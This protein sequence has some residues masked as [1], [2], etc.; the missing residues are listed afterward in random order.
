[1]FRFAHSSV[2]YLLILVPLLIAFFVV[3]RMR[4]RRALATFGED[5]LLAPLMPLTSDARETFKFILLILA[6][7]LLIIGAAG[8]QFGSKL[9]QVKK[10]GVELEILI[11]VSNSMLAEDIKPN[12]LERSKMAVERMM[13]RLYDDKVGVIIFAGDAYVQ[14]PITTDYSAAKL[15]LSS[16]STT[17]VPIQGTAIGRA[18]DLAMRSFSP[19][20]ST[21]KAIIIITDGENHEDDAV[22]AARSARANGIYVHTIGM[23]LEQGAPIPDGSGGYLK[24][25]EGNTVITKLDERLLREIAAAGDGVYVRASNSD[26]GLNTVLDEIDS[27]QKSLMEEKVYDSYDDKYYYFLWT[28]L[29]LLLFEHFVLGRKNRYLMK[30]DL[31]KHRM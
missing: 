5:T 25:S 2:L 1:M 18:I 30:I 8:P 29:F 14:I 12:R 11:D 31:F 19:D 13:S 17:S 16:I 22:V 7:T 23:G 15:F 21:S 3:M 6:L 9:R 10:E 27:M 20:E 28:A 26:V 4:K 24:D